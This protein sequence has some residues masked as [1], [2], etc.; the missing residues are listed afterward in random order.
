[1]PW[2]LERSNEEWAFFPNG[3][4]L[5]GVCR[6]SASQLAGTAPPICVLALGMC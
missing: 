3:S 5:D 4:V 6:V 2:G 1:M